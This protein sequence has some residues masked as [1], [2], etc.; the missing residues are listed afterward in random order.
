MSFAGDSPTTDRQ[1]GTT[2]TSTTTTELLCKPRPPL[3]WLHRLNH[4]R[5]TAP[6]STRL[7]LLWV[8]CHCPATATGIC[9][10]SRRRLDPDT[11]G[12]LPDKPGLAPSQPCSAQLSSAQHS[13][14]QHKLRSARLSRGLPACSCSCSIGPRHR[15][16]PLQH[17]A[18]CWGSTA[19]VQPDRRLSAVLGPHRR[20]PQLGGPLRLG[21]HQWEWDRGRQWACARPWDWERER[22]WERACECQWEWHCDALCPRS[23]LPVW[24]R[25]PCR[26]RCLP[27]LCEQP[28]LL[29][30]LLAPSS[31]PRLQCPVLL[32][33]GSPPS[34][35]RAK[36][37]ASLVSGLVHR[38]DAYPRGICNNSA[39][40]TSSV[41]A[42]LPAPAVWHH[43]PSVSMS[44]PA[45][46]TRARAEAPP[47]TQTSG[48]HPRPLMPPMSPPRAGPTVAPC[49]SEPPPPP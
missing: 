3:S 29:S 20:R 38:A 2:A 34:P 8:S 10:Y 14:A 39:A 47:T 37:L 33:A 7:P 21:H 41:T 36:L 27:G 18:A 11:R 48:T 13:S 23:G 5:I 32:P 43:S 40:S 1:T 24:P 19:L 49:C 17:A 26:A 25:G 45:A 9:P 16:E 4:C 35:G 22:E 28:S 15:H 46:G 6:P 30:P 44:P 42:R 31:A 12:A